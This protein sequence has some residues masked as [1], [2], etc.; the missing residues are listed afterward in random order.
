MYNKLQVQIMAGVHPITFWL[1][2][3]LWDLMLFTCVSLVLS[4]VMYG[5][6]ERMILSTNGAAGALFLLNFLFG[7]GGILM[8]YV[9]SF[10]TKSAPSAFTFF[11]ILS[12]VAGVLAPI[13]VYF[14]DLFR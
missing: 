8:A 5:L 13:A 11:V 12:L 10:A 2:N 6:D 14:L 7:L 4:G 9:F 1:S 3:L